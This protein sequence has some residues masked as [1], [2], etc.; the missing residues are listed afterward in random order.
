MSHDSVLPIGVF[1]PTLIMLVA[2]ALFTNFGDAWLNLPP[3]PN[4]EERSKDY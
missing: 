3:P 2:Q 1:L 4:I